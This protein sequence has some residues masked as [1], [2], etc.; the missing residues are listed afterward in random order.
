MPITGAKNG[1]ELYDLRGADYD[2]SRWEQLLDQLNTDEMVELIA[3]GG[4]QTA[5]VRSVGKVRTLDTDG[6]AG[7]NST[8]INAFGT[9][10]CS[11]ILIAQ[12]WNRPCKKSR[13]R[14]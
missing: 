8:T 7:L 10:Y 13:R 11:E 4:H 2:D 5:A 12:T 14:D 9:G 3:Y 1:L 6:P